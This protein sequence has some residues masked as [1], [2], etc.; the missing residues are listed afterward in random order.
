L[1]KQEIIKKES[2]EKLEVL[3][4]NITSSLPQEL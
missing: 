3:R 4:R 1:E 2:T